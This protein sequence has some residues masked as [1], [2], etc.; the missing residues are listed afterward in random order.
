MCTLEVGINY[1]RT[2]RRVK[3]YIIDTSTYKMCT[4]ENVSYERGGYYERHLIETYW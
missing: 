3:K 4:L 1:K 2:L